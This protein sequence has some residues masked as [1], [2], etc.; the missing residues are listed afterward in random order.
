M[1]TKGHGAPKSHRAKQSPPNPFRPGLASPVKSPG[2]SN[3]RTRHQN[4]QVL[5]HAQP[6]SMAPI[7]NGKTEFRIKNKNAGFGGII[8]DREDARK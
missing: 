8:R 3:Y 5:S 7:S 4:P 6:T 1:A 2:G